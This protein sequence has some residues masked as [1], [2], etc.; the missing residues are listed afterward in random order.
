MAELSSCQKCHVFSKTTLTLYRENILPISIRFCH[1]NHFVI[2]RVPYQKALLLFNY[3]KPLVGHRAQGSMA[4]G[5][6]VKI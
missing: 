3:G 6:L 1:L 2:Y 4:L 5:Q